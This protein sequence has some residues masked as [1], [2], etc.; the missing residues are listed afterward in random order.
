[1]DFQILNKMD[2]N[3]I[4]AELRN[5][6]EY[7][8]FLQVMSHLSSY[9]W[10]NIFLIYR[11]LPHA[12]KLADYKGWKNHGRTIIPGIT[13]I[14]INDPTPHL[15]KKKVVESSYMDISQTEGKPVLFVAGD[16][17]S[18]EALR[19]AFTDSLKTMSASD[20]QSDFY[21]LI[22]QIVCKRFE[23]GDSNNAG[24]I[25]DSIALVVCLR[26][27]IDVNTD[28]IGLDRWLDAKTLE[29]IGKYSDGLIT[30]IESRFTIICQER[31]IDHMTL[32]RT[33]EGKPKTE[34]PPIAT[35]EA[36]EAPTLKHLPDKAIT[37]P[38]RN[39]Y[40]YTRP[41]L[42]PLT[43]D[44]AISLFRRDM[45]VYLLYK[46]NTEI[47]AHYLSDIQN[48]D[49]I[50]GMAYGAWLNSRE[51]IA[52]A[53]GNPE[54]QREAGFI[55]DVGDSF[56]IYQAEPD[57]SPAAYKSYEELQAKGFDINRHN[58]NLIYTAPL[59]SPP[60]DTPEG[61]F[62]WVTT[63]QLEDYDGRILSISDVLSIKKDEI[64]TSYY[65]NGRTFKELLSFTGE[66]GR[67]SVR[68]VEVIVIEKEQAGQRKQQTEQII[69][70]PEA[71][72]TV[73][74]ETTAAVKE[75][76]PA[77][78]PAVMQQ[79][80]Q[81]KT[82]AVSSTPVTSELPPPA[83]PV[84]RKESPFYRLS[85]KTAEEH[86]VMELFNISRRVDIECANA[87]VEL[88]QKYREGENGYNLATPAEELTKKYGKE[89]IQWVLSC[90][91]NASEKG[92]AE[93][94]VAWAKEFLGDDGAD[95][96]IRIDTHNTLL[97]AL[98]NQLLKEP[99]TFKEKMEDAKK[100]SET[101]N[102]SNG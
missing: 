16:V 95:N 86:G 7:R 46:N 56:A 68:E 39:K 35:V 98:V 20:E 65:A 80:V 62:M 84:N 54:A 31:G 37:V 38:E 63:E 42:L 69:T 27:G 55:Y 61:L 45:T 57:D 96:P 76:A 92:F 53:S 82:P 79:A 22:K 58:Y 2:V 48:H 72:K 85:A 59:P 102:K 13:G 81:A 89:R 36:A 41:E 14:K 52:L 101:H 26:F 66:E 43:K 24:F 67:R 28:F 5:P 71:I 83:L 44:R 10:H 74:T 17:L 77:S 19:G 64:I 78:E 51:Y 97:N 12:T 32:P 47:M 9:S 30:D 100:K 8:G 50:F 29:I 90:H 91:I 49:G 15:P 25:T 1:M 4:L 18:D 11:Q 23:N 21:G 73:I 33:A 40:G 70:P 34:P 94:N 87:I 99:T 75:K 6:A 93:N 88:I 3:D 60:S